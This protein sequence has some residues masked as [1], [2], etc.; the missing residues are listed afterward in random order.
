MDDT[1]TRIVTIANYNPIQIAVRSVTTTVKSSVVK[2]EANGELDN[3]EELQAIASGSKAPPK[4]KF[5]NNTRGLR[6]GKA[7]PVHTVIK[8]GHAANVS[9]TVQATSS[10]KVSGILKIQT[11]YEMITINVVYRG[12]Q[13]TVKLS[14]LELTFAPGLPGKTLKSTKSGTPKIFELQKL[15]KLKLY[16]EPEERG[17]RVE[18]VY[19][20]DSRFVVKPGAIMGKADLWKAGTDRVELASV[21]FTPSLGPASSNYV[22][23]L[24]STYSTLVIPP[25]NSDTIGEVDRADRVWR[26]L[27][28]K[29]QTNITATIVIDT[30]TLDPSLRQKY[31]MQKCKKG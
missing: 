17:A 29:K 2:L 15:E 8:P 28:K 12:M 14:P 20:E 3:E 30:N 11:K 24:S 19:S 18:K 10:G 7:A 23:S 16:V 4:M 9:I 6:P 27:K 1:A 22:P 5:N 26:R 31:K 13:R 21:V 25:L